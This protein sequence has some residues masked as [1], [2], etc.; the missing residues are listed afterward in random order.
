MTI[1]RAHLY[2]YAGNWRTAN[3]TRFKV[4]YITGTQAALNRHKNRDPREAGWYWRANW[5]IS[6]RFNSSR[7]AWRNARVKLSEPKVVN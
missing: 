7:A 2:A 5:I 6:P 3:G 1:P 4:E